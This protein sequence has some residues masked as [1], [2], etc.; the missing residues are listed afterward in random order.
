M[1][2]RHSSTVR[3]QA[4]NPPKD[5]KQ[6]ILDCSRT[7]FSERSFAQVSLKDIAEAA[8]VSAPLII[9]HFQSK[10]N[11]FEQTVDFT[12]SAQSLFKGPF[13]QL[14]ITAA[15]ETLT[16]PTTAS[17]SIIRTMTIT[18]G[19]ERSLNA[20]GARIKRDILN[21]LATRIEQEAPLPYPAPEL[22]AQAA[23]ALLTGLS[24]MR[25]VGD[26]EFEHYSQEE[27]TTY[28]GGLVQRIIDG[29]P[30]PDN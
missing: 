8:G 25:R 19:S 7:L 9:K 20:I 16:A 27:L 6:R 11:L 12:V 30:T 3:R 4:A 18:D 2:Q 15:T 24:L 1:E 17:Y 29:R 13:E 10:E 28:Y 23:M 22:R 14:G 26:T 21:V 5:S